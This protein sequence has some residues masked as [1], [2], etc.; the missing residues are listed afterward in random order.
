MRVIDAI[1]AE[2]AAAK[3]G[4]E[5]DQPETDAAARYD[6]DKLNSALDTKI[7]YLE[8]RIV[9]LETRAGVV[10]PPPNPAP[11]PAHE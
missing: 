7:A 4:A 3:A 10:A 9:E 6:W 1:K 8:S 5:S 2:I 11:V